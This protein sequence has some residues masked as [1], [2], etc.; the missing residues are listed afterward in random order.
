M[1]T[2]QASDQAYT[3]THPEGLMISLIKTLEV[4][5]SQLSQCL[6]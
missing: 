5:F 6:G 2:D 4:K 1:K 3:A